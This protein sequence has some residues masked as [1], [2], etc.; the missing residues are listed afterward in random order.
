MKNKAAKKT[1][2]QTLVTAV[3]NALS[4]KKSGKIVRPK[5]DVVSLRK[6]LKMTQKD[7][8]KTYHINLQTLRNW[9]QNKRIPDLTTQA[10]LTCIAKSP[11]QIAQLVH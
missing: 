2:G 5:F 8:S 9:E 11:K 7:F 6:T 1:M 4:H 10:Y 3:R